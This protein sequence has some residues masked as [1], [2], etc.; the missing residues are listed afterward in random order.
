MLIF[1][2]YFIK[3]CKELRGIEPL[4][5]LIE[6]SSLIFSKHLEDSKN[7]STVYHKTY[8]QFSTAGQ[9]QKHDESHLFKNLFGSKC[10]SSTKILGNPFKIFE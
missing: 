8:S 3:L 5:L 2:G 6:L 1:I 7:Q 10:D 4:S 9:T